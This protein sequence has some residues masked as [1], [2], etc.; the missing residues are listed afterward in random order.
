M[1]GTRPASPPLDELPP[2]P[3]L[4]PLE[5]PELLDPPELLEPC[6][7]PELLELEEPPELLEL[8]EL[9]DPPEPLDPPELE[10]L[11]LFPPS[12]ALEVCPPQ[13]SSAAAA[14]TTAT[15][16]RRLSF[17]TWHRSNT[18]TDC[19]NAPF[20]RPRAPDGGTSGTPA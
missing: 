7:S 20:S 18:R 13:A 8:L 6:E 2:G 10:E 14:R 17:I 15:L 4:E 16:V 5:P 11:P 3:L 12:G 1:A 9:E 19:S